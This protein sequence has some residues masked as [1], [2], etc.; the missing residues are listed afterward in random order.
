MLLAFI[1]GV[2]TVQYKVFPF[3]QLKALVRFT[4][5]IVSPKHSDYYYHKKSFFEL[6]GKQSYDI[7]FI[8]D[9]ITDD[10]EWHDL[11]P[12]VKIANRGIDGDRTDG[13]LNR[14]DSI[15]STSAPKAFMMMGI[16]DFFYGTSVNEVFDN[17]KNIVNH[18]L[19][20]KIK[21]FIQST[22]LAG[23][24]YQYLNDNILSLNKRLLSLSEQID[25][26]TY[27]DLNV[28]LTSDS[29]LK[30]TY[31]QDDVHLNGEG[32]AIWKKIIN[33]YIQP[34]E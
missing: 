20:R 17:Y 22:I 30:T 11:F 15:D 33:P 4:N 6:H 19:D 24:Q 3:Y 1:Y 31:S 12:S 7:V 9:S 21:V 8:G 23:K 2:A 13:V 14:L 28:G 16:N 5:T 26:V 32:Y 25:S 34:E 18:L 10:A 27:I 29:L